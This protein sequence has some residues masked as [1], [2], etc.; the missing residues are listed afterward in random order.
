MNARSNSWR[1]V[2]AAIWITAL[3]ILL[4]WLIWALG[5]RIGLVEHAHKLLAFLL[6]ITVAVLVRLVPELVT[7]LKR[8]NHREQ[9]QADKVYATSDAQIIFPRQEGVHFSKLRTHLR[10]RHGLFWRH[11]IRLLLVIGEPSQIEALAPTLTEH[12]WLEGQ[13]TVL[14]WG[15]S[16]QAALD[17]S[18]LD[19]WKGPEQNPGHR[20][21]RDGRGCASVAEFGSK[22]GL[23]VAFAPMAGLRQSMVPD[24]P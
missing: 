7:H 5:E 24:R 14:L 21:C 8:Q 11:K 22:P 23:A 3:F 13:G 1:R 6:I 20:R 15:G 9:G 18:F 10:H 12:F 17:R 16:A 4:A 19:Q 2:G